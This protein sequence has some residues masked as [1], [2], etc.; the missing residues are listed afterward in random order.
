MRLQH[1]TEDQVY[2]Q[3]LDDL[4]EDMRVTYRCIKETPDEQSAVVKRVPG[5]FSD[6]KPM[7]PIYFADANYRAAVHERAKAKILEDDK[8]VK[9][10]VKKEDDK[11]KDDA[12]KKVDGKKKDGEKVTK[13]KPTTKKN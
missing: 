9:A 8:N 6:L 2:A 3:S 7:T 10:P 4:G 11:K 13:K 1:T 12:K 5:G